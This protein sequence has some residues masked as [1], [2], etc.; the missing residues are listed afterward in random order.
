M[1]GI[2]LLLVGCFWHTPQLTR[3][4]GVIVESRP[5]S[6]GA[7]Y[8]VY[9]YTAHGVRYHGHRLVRYAAQYESMFEVGR[10]I[11]VF[12]VTNDPEDT[13]GPNAPRIQAFIIIGALLIAVAFG[14]FY[15]TGHEHLTKRWSQRHPT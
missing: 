2:A 5:A 15:L 4:T 1:V 13:Y 3:T 8:I 12:F 7:R 6:V 10:S 14:I 9:E 11:P